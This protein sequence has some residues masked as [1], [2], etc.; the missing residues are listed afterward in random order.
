MP[1]PAGR[2]SIAGVHPRSVGP[3]PRSTYTCVPLVA[4]T[5]VGCSDQHV[6]KTMPRPRSLGRGNAVAAR[7]PR[8]RHEPSLV[9]WLQVGPFFADIRLPRPGRYS[10][11]S[12][13][14]AQGF[15]GTLCLDNGLARWRHDLDTVGR[16]P[17]HLDRA[18]LERH[19]PQMLERGE[20]YVEYWRQCAP[21]NRAPRGPR[22]PLA[23]VA[24]GSVAGLAA[25]P[26]GGL[27]AVQARLLKVGTY[28]VAV[29]SRPEPGACLFARRHAL[30]S[31]GVVLYNRVPARSALGRGRCRGLSSRAAGSSCCSW[32]P[33]SWHPRPSRLD[34]A[35][36]RSAGG[37]LARPVLISRMV[38][39]EWR[40]GGGHLL[41]YRPSSCSA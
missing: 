22:A 17:G 13:D 30:T 39:T 25:H 34:G 35:D 8:A 38:A 15:S 21:A 16:V 18:T 32:H 24:C 11:H 7:S 14:A 19:G 37:G 10:T 5:E 41:G 27:P 12:L 6:K 2:S 23:A 29:W 26:A 33:R 20:G 28:A 31:A 40:V 4:E 1:A 3:A 9:I 36:E